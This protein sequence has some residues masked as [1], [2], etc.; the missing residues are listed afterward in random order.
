M[1]KYFYTLLIFLSGI[2]IGQP[3]TSLTDIYMGAYGFWDYQSSGSLQALEQDSSNMTRY[4]AVYLS[5][6]STFTN[7]QKRTYYF[8]SSNNGL[9]WS[10]AQVSG[11]NASY[12]ALTLQ[13]DGNAV[14]GF[15]DSSNTRIRFY[16]TTSPGAL[17]FDTLTSL[18]T[19]N[20]N[21]KLLFYKNYLVLFALSPAGVLQKTRYKYSTS[22]W[23]SWVTVSSNVL[24]AYQ[25]AKGWSGRFAV[26]WLAASTKQV[27]YSES[28][29]SADTFGSASTVFTQ[30]LAGADT[31]KAYAHVDMVYYN[32]Q[33]CITWDAIAR[34]LPY[35]GQEGIMKFYHNPRIYFWNQTNGVKIVSD[36]SNG[37]SP[38][39]PGRNFQLSM[40]ANWSTMCG[41]TIGVSGY[42]NPNYMFIAYSAAKTAFPFGNFWFDS[43]IFIK[44]T[45]SNGAFWN[46]CYPGLTTD[47]TNDDR[48]VFINKKANMAFGYSYGFVVQKDKFP[49]SYRAGDTTAITRA[50]PE[51]YYVNVII[52]TVTEF[53]TPEEFDLCPNYPNPFNNYTHIEFWIPRSGNVE[54]TIYD[55][56]GRKIQTLI[57]ASEFSNVGTSHVVFDGTN[58]PSGI[59][60]CR[61]FMDG[62]LIDVKKMVLVK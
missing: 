4:H 58:Y 2:V 49:G 32:N 23:E 41:P 38:S 56:L 57:E 10:N 30:E 55:V 17:T 59:Y 36:S 19:L 34:I 31:V 16:R 28:L 45:S 35:T 14:I 39:F 54:L 42:T 50:Y 37:G 52:H 43:D 62:E 47:N 48:F 15:Y 8:Y 22:T 60:F 26:C 40:G 12:P 46:L 24:T 6:D 13:T 11:F 53:G 44:F 51:F 3:R 29:D 7:P 21:P 5:A 27:M 33:P 25:I 1:L 18:S 61:M 20:Q 9:N